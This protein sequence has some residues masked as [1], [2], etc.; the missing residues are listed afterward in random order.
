MSWFCTATISRGEAFGLESATRP[1]AH[2]SCT[3]RLSLPAAGLSWLTAQTTPALH[4]SRYTAPFGQLSRKVG[5]IAISPSRSSISSESCGTT[6]SS[7][8]KPSDSPAQPAQGP[9]Q[10][11]QLERI[12]AAYAERPRRILAHGAH[13]PARDVEEPQYLA[14]VLREEIALLREAHATARAAEEP[15]RPARPRASLSDGSPPA[16]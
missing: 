2:I 8:I 16:A 6:R 4:S 15:D 1:R 10:Q 9:R 3:L 11:P 13:P 7:G 5:I 14:G 12:P